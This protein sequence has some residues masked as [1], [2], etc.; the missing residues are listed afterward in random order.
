MFNILRH[1]QHHFFF[2]EGYIL[3][4]VVANN[5]VKNLEDE[6]TYGSWNTTCYTVDHSYVQ[7]QFKLSGS[8]YQYSDYTCYDESTLVS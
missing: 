4:S 5:Y 1:I 3:G 6:H 7:R 2:F 8:E